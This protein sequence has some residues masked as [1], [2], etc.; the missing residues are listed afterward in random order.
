MKKS[1]YSAAA[2]VVASLVT[3]SAVQAGGIDRSV[4]PYAILWEKG[5]Y[6]ELSFG[7]VMPKVS[8]VSAARYGAQASGDM[9][10]D[11][12]Q[13]GAGVKYALSDKLDLAVVF[14]QP[15]GAKIDYPSNALYPLKDSNA[16]IKSN[17]LTA[18]ARY[19]LDNGF[20]V[21]GGIKAQ[22]T[23]GKVSLRSGAYK[24]Q[25]STE[26]DLGYIL[27]VAY[28]RPDIA[29][30]VALTYQSE[31]THDFQSRELDSL[32]TKFSTEV[33][34]S[35]TLDFQTGVAPKTLVFGSV[36]W[37][38]WS[39]FKIDPPVYKGITSLSGGQ[40]LVTY[41]HDVVT[42]TLGVGHKFTDNWA[43]AISVA[44][45]KKHDTKVGNLGPVNGMTAITLG[46]TYTQDKIKIT[47][48]VT[49]AKLGDGTTKLLD[50]QFKDN[51]TVGVG[52][53]IGYS[54]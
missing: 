23:E 33:P 16:E 27:G 26:T 54:F 20:S 22:R 32:N 38:E 39:A 48:G 1:V 17:A 53:K 50:S 28:E 47:G 49:Y 25:T 31:I 29:M 51:H 2:T 10:A 37:R 11:F 21:H 7:R 34:K 52:F 12:S 30:R 4:S 19:K 35:W 5:N 3:A 6:A 9:L 8:G 13:I 40:A 24:M 44:H 45:E 18:L 42:Y 15:I 43:G 41:D 36:R 46:G 14:D